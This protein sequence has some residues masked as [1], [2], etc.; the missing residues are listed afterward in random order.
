[1]VASVI[2]ATAIIVTAAHAITDRGRIRED[3]PIGMV[4]VNATSVAEIVDRTEITTGIAMTAMADHAMADQT[5]HAGDDKFSMMNTD[6]ISII[7]H[8]TGD[9]VIIHHS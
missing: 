6:V 9:P 2:S 8:R 1:M 7:H 4:A 5:Y 3:A